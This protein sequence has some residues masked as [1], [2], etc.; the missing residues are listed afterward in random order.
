MSDAQLKQLED[1]IKRAQKFVDMGEALERLYMNKDFR[2]VV[3]EGYFEQ[4]AIRLVHLKSDSNM[5]STDSQKSIIQQID[6]VGSL[7]QFFNLLSY[8]A[9]MAGKTIA[10]DEQTREDILAEGN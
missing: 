2:K 9:E 4:E 5:Q 1:S 10:F 6:A 7:K 3:V 8:Q